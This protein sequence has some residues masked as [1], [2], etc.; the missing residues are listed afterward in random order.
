MIYPSSHNH[1]SVEN[2]PKWKET[3]IGG[4]TPIFHFHDYGKKGAPLKK[5]TFP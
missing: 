2:H 1:G 5:K 4:G 3:H